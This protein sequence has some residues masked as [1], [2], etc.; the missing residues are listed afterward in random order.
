MALKTSLQQEKE[1]FMFMLKKPEYLL[2]V[3]KD[4]FTNDDLQYVAVT[5]RD[6]YKKFREAPSCEQMKRL[7][8]DND[9]NI[10]D[11]TVDNIYSVDILSLD[12][13]WLMNTTEGWIMWRAFNTNLVK[14][15]AYIKTV[16]VSVEN[17]RDV[18]KRAT[19]MVSD[20][21]LISFDKNMGKNFFDVD[22][23]KSIRENK[24]PFT[25]DYWNSISS[26]GLDPKTLHVYIGFTNVGKSIVLCN[27]AAAFVRQGKNVLFISCEMSEEKV[28]RRIGAN[29]FDMTLDNYDKMVDSPSSVRRQ[30]KNLTDGSFMPLGKLYVK[31]YPTGECTALDIERYV[32]EIEEQE[33]F[34]VDVV[35]VDYLG[36]MCDY[37]N[38]NTENTYLKGKHISEDLRAV[39][40]KHDLI[41]DTAAQ[42][43]RS[44]GDSSD[45]NI[46]DISESMG[47]M[48]TADSSIGLIQTEEM[49]YGVNN[50]GTPYYWFKI[51]KVREGEGKDTKF[52][53]NIDYNKMKLNETT[54]I[55]NSNDHLK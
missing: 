32:K 55:I 9:K 48:H 39:A 19:D 13:D 18:V 35:I 51:L 15:A 20:T 41:I 43:G 14:S 36:I 11:E 30:M 45:I 2:E 10:T 27:D 16:D 52:K 37:R 46:T 6:F 34:K 21:S 40:I 54:D 22:S 53:V 49:R 42:I 47:V 24:I 33:K 44:A 5:A 1:I 26:G 7:I 28:I 3:K 38:P 50:D 12:Q 8:K 4:F 23:H 17:V 25:W 31:Q 29:L